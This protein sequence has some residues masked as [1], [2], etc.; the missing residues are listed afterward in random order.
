MTGN[1]VIDALLLT[2]RTLEDRPEEVAQLRVRLLPQ[3]GFDIGVQPFVLITAHRRENFGEG[4]ENICRALAALAR[5][6]VTAT[7]SDSS[8]SSYS[9]PPMP[10]GETIPGIAISCDI[11][12]PLPESSSHVVIWSISGC[13]AFAIRSARSRIAGFVVLDCAMVASSTA[14]SWWGIIICAN[15][16]SF[17][18]KSLDELSIIPWSGD[19]P[20]VFVAHP[21]SPMVTSPVNVA[22]A[23]NFFMAPR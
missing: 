23:R 17:M 2:I 13:C 20:A 10:T 14:C 6:A 18:L 5:A 21:L 19:E 11:S 1:T 12:M 3:I 8:P 4:F 15:M 16:M 9:V 7:G 22:T